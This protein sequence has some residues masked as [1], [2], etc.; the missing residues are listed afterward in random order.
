MR[1]LLGQAYINSCVVQISAEK[2][3]A[4]NLK[5]KQ[6]PCYYISGIFFDGTDIKIGC[7]YAMNGGQN[8][9]IKIVIPI[10]RE[11]FQYFIGEITDLIL[12]R[13][14]D[15]LYENSFFARIVFFFLN[16]QIQ[17]LY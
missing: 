12:L 16:D 4:I 5:K 14:R 11:M 3:I 13:E 1:L 10:R 9:A 8:H 2:G 15:A 6:F 7:D 17:T